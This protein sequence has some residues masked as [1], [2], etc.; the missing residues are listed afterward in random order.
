MNLEKNEDLNKGESHRANL[1]SL[2]ILRPIMTTLVMATVLFLGAL[3]FWQLPVSNMPNVDYPV[4]T[5][6]ATLPGASPE[7]MAGSVASPLENEFMTIPGVTNV[8]SSNTLG[9]TNIVLEFDVN[10]NINAAA[11]DVEAGITRAT[12]RLPTNLLTPPTYKKVNP[13]DSPIM[14]LALTSDTLTL[15][16]LYTYARTYLGQRLSTID[17]VAQV[18][19]YGAPYAVRVQVD[20]G[21]LATRNITLQEVSDAIV[22]ASPNKPT[23]QLD[24]KLLSYI[25]HSE[26]QLTKASEYESVIVAYKD[27]AP[28]RVSDIGDAIDATNNVRIHLTY[29]NQEKMQPTVVLAIQRQPGANTVAVSDAVKRY[30]PKLTEQLPASL[31]L[32]IVF[33]L[34][35]SIRNSVHEV[36][37]TLLIALLLVVAV[38]FFYLGNLRDTLIPS[39]TMPMAIIGT[40]WGMNALGYSLDNL[41]LL[42]LTL[43]T[44]FIVDD[45]IV[46][47]ENIVRRV[48]GGESRLTASIKGSSQIS[49]TILSMTL[50]LIA[51]FIPMLFMAGLMGKILLEFSMTLVIV[52]IASGIISLTL[53]PMMCSRFVTVDKKESA[54]GRISE[55]FNGLMLSWYS[56]SLTKVM[57]YHKTMLFAGALSIILSL[58][59]FV[60]VPKD[61]IPDDDIGF[62][63]GFTQAAEGTSPDKMLEMQMQI[64]EIVRNDPSVES[65][66]SIAGNPQ[67]RQGI[68]FLHLKPIDKRAPVQEVVQGLYGKLS[69]VVGMQVFLKNIPLINLSAGFN[70]RGAY[71]YTMQSLDTKT[72]YPVA[73]KV[74]ARL[75]ALPELQG[76]SSD[77]DI[78]TPQLNIEVLRDQAAALGITADAVEKTLGFAYSGNRVTKIETPYDQYD[79][80]LELKPKF[81]EKAEWL[82]QI[83]MRASNDFNHKEELIPLNSVANWTEGVGP[84]SVNHYLQFPAVTVSFNL[85]PHVALG[86]AVKAINQVTMEELP[87][88]VT[89]SLQ[90]AAQKFEETIKSITIL[91][92]ISLFAIYVIL[93]ILYESFIHPLTIL[94]SLP[95]ALLG[96]LLT[97]Y[98]FNMP[99]SIYGYLGIILLI[100]IVKKNGIMMIDYAIE[101]QREKG[102][103]PK[104]AIY[105]ACLVRF[106]PIMMTTVAA[107]MGALP[108]AIGFG[109]GGEAR[110]P[111]GLVIIG[112][113][114]LSQLVTLYITPM[115]YLFME[116]IAHGEEK[117]GSS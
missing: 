48:E 11:Q 80:I 54:I 38:I 94:S 112:G 110:R 95:P 96:G 66:V 71:Q 60:I 25:I 116:R 43:A 22:N 52:I 30:L 65:F 46:V 114:L 91:L 108:V 73:E 17:G 39:V 111:L 58:Y 85:S 79:V 41:S 10:K 86:D 107:I 97:I 104:K 75:S 34:S 26:S 4:I 6:T 56:K 102:E 9:T 109:S 89:G 36:E 14:Y 67:V 62:I 59:L 18:L 49:F 57:E 77:L 101:N 87:D 63:Q 92:V 44:G 13:S 78:Y 23:G 40:F 45:A 2:F 117:E 98:I 82:N 5:V 35:E 8:I 16:D 100:G 69:Q 53:T 51:V 93:G 81:Q 42:A 20:P 68:F 12:P 33:D 106:R 15:G 31:D 105:D 24:G 76:V 83:Y 74:I 28:I 64:D 103:S 19:T 27:G 47:L 72:L 113:L 21:Q 90:G 37:I 84:S 3:G 88:N 1:S 55:R 7:T 32:N 99:L 29:V 61:F 70:V 50:S 115:I